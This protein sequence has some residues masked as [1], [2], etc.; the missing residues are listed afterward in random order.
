LEGQEEEA[1][2]VSSFKTACRK[3]F[4]LP[5]GRATACRYFGEPWYAFQAMDLSCVPDL[6]F[7]TES[8][9]AI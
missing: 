4:E 5:Y 8:I 7:E 3:V 1:L 2:E 9:G 6:F